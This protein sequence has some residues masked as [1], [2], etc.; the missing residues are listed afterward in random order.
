MTLKKETVAELENR[1]GLPSGDLATKIADATEH[2]IDLAPF[3]FIKTTDLTTREGNLRKEGF[4]EGKIAGEEILVKAIRDEFG[5]EK[6]ALPKKANAKQIKEVIHTSVAAELKIS[7]D[8]RIGELTNDITA[9]QDTVKKKD[10]KISDLTS[11]YQRKEQ[12]SAIR[13]T[14]LGKIPDKTKIPKEDVLNLF[15]S[16]HRVELADDGKLV[17]KNDEGIMKNET[18]RAPLTID[19]VIPTFITPYLEGP[20]GGAGGEDKP[21]QSTGAPGTMAAFI[22]EMET[23]GKNPSGSEAIQEMRR[24]RKAG[25]LKD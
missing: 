19:E 25:T 8:K 2:E 24:R 12:Q 3:T 10:E 18:T 1:L 16:K 4:D 11:S 14:I 13:H 7:P 23:A 15:M 21:N 22:K 6:A 17:F 9:L 5:I 20:G